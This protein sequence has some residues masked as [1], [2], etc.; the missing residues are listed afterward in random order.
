MGKRPFI[1]KFY[2]G[3]KLLSTIEVDAY[4]YSTALALAIVKYNEGKIANW[5]I[6]AGY[7]IRVAVKNR[8]E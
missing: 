1:A 4:C 7:A 6:K 2:Q 8:V 5:P 3:R